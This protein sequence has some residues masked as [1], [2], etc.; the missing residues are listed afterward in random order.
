I[1]QEVFMMRFPSQDHS[2]ATRPHIPQDG[3]TLAEQREIENAQDVG[4][5]PVETSTADKLRTAKK[6]AQQGEREQAY[7]LSKEA[8]IAE[9]EDIDAWLLRGAFADNNEERLACISKATSLAPEHSA[10]KYHLYDTLRGYLEEDPF[11]RYIEETDSL[12]RVLT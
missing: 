4:E 10:A 9:P 3:K 2:D 6:A 7:Q 12:Y 8:T 5:Y 11:L 1:T